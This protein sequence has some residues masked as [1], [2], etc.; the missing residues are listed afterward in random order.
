MEFFNVSATNSCPIKS[1]NFCGLRLVA[2]TS[3]AIK[4]IYLKK[5]L[6]TIHFLFL[7]YQ[8]PEEPPP[9]K[10]PPPPPKDLEEEFLYEDE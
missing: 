9:P 10:E 1:L 6:F 8:R 7:P 3:Y 2:V 5:D 4:R